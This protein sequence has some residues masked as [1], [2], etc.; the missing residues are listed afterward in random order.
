MIYLLK[1][2]IFH[3]ELLNNQRVYL[4]I[5][6]WFEVINLFIVKTFR[7]KH[8]KNVLSLAVKPT[9]LV[10]HI[11]ESHHVPIVLLEQPIKFIHLYMNMKPLKPTVPD[12][13]W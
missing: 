7:E 5:Q 8:R 1:M 6:I 9:F 10:G 4:S 12:N 3:G 11:H 13:F 2:V